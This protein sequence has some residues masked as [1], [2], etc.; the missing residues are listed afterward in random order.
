MLFEK[1]FICDV[2]NTLGWP[3]TPCSHLSVTGRGRGAGMLCTNG[4]AHTL[5][6]NL[7]LAASLQKLC[8]RKR[9]TFGDLGQKLHNHQ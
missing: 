3:Q 4:P 9:H 5:E 2:E 1:G 6:G 7:L 8:I